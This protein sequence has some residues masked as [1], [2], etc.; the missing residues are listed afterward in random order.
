MCVSFPR[1]YPH[2]RSLLTDLRLSLR[3]HNACALAKGNNK[4]CRAHSSCAATLHCS[5]SDNDSRSQ[6]NVRA[7]CVSPQASATTPE[8]TIAELVFAPLEDCCLRV[9]SGDWA[10]R[11]NHLLPGLFS[12]VHLR[13]FCTYRW[14]LGL[15]FLR[16]NKIQA[17]P[18]Y[19][20]HR[21]LVKCSC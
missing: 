1:S 10:S 15:A 4:S 16:K 18:N 14:Y 7:L 20:E 12:A 8:N 2:L 6:C 5:L 3:R 9:P 11:T 19:I 13:Q 21:L 17:T